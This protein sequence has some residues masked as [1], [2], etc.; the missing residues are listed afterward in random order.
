MYINGYGDNY[1][2]DICD[3]LLKAE[4]VVYINDWVFG[5]DIILNLS[6]KRAR[7]CTL[8]N[9]LIELNKKGVKVYILLYNNVTSKK[10]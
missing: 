7:E 8:I 6:P 1:F 10:S 3:E 9:I 2:H 5:E 4:K